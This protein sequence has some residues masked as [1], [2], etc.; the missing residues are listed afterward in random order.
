MMP[1]LARIFLV[2]T[3]LFYILYPKKSRKQKRLARIELILRKVC[4]QGLSCDKKRRPWSSLPMTQGLQN[5]YIFGFGVI[6]PIEK[7]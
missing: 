2:Q 6:H 5:Y 7:G 1:L 3:F 4:G